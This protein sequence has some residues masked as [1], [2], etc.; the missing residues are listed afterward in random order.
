MLNTFFSA[1]LANYH[2]IKV[3]LFSNVTKGDNVP[4]LLYD[5]HGFLEKL[6]IS[7]Q[8]FL[9]G[10]VL[11]ECKSKNKIELGKEYSIGIESF[12]M[13]PL[14]VND[15]IYFHSFNEDYFYNENDLGA[16]YSKEK[17]TF[18][19]WAPLASKVVLMLKKPTENAKFE[20]YKME[21]AEKGVYQITINGDLERYLY[22]YQVTNSGNTNI[23]IDPYGKGSDSNGKNSIVI[24]L[25]KTKVDLFSNIPPV[26]KQYVDTIIYELHVRDFTINQNTNIVNKGKFLGLTEEGR[27]TKNG[28]PAGLDYLKALNITHVQ[29]LPVLDYKT[30]NEDDPSERYNWGY[31]PQQYFSLEGS[32][33]T[34]PNDPYSRIIEFKQLV[35]SLHKNGLRVNLDVVYNHVYD[36]QMSTFEMIV[37]GYYFRRRKNGLMSNGTGC[38]NDLA[39]EKPMVRKLIIDSLKY[40]LSEFEVDGFRFD[41]IGITDIDT[42]KQIVSELRKINPNVMLYGEGWDMATELPSDKKTTI[43]NAFK[44]PEIAFF[45]DAF[46]DIARGH[47][48]TNDVGYLLGNNDF[49]EGFKF[50]FLGSCTNYCFNARFLNANQSINY[51]ECHD[52]KTLFDKIEELIASDKDLKYKLRVVNFVNCAIVF[53][54]GIPFFHAGQEIGQSKEHLDNTYNLPDKYN[55]FR[56]DLVDERIENVL[57]FSSILNSRKQHFIMKEVEK[58]E[59]LKKIDFIDLNDD[60]LCASYDLATTDENYL[61]VFNPFD[62][63]HYIDL[64]DYYNV[65]VG[66]GGLLKNSNLY[67]QHLAI[68]SKSLYIL[69]KR[70][71]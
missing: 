49:E 52:N 68:E 44:T 5:N 56:R 4:I 18:K 62:E 35:Q 53:S 60:C 16:N 22:R 65:V 55:E 30:V 50:V 36:Y 8:S 41:L 1:K 21:R 38:G 47:N 27:K 58:E 14:D 31:D 37:P 69:K 39:S 3:A 24:D 34:N 46:R 61:L 7:N 25:S 26:Y 19:V 64:K 45:N 15:A 51:V 63:K 9:N 66:A 17:T 28:N 32:F 71:K 42:T 11:Y 70:K 43:L 67:T 54:F 33:S 48:F 10:L 2:T 57:F 23:V 13:V 12:G 29:L 40:L 59:I 6:T 20:T